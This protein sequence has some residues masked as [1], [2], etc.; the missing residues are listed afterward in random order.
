MRLEKVGRGIDCRT[1]ADRGRGARGRHRDRR[2]Q[3]QSFGSGRRGTRGLLVLAAAA[4][5]VLALA[6]CGGGSS[7][8]SNRTHT[9]S[10]QAQQGGTAYLAEGTQA[11][12][13]YIFPFASLQYFSTTNF[14]GFMNLLYRPL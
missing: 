3:M 9:S 11:A 7:S 1:P 13:N 14:Q 5:V 10:A 6:A 8:S 12:P 4:I 2:K